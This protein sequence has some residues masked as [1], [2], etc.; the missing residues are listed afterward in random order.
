MN[1][2]IKLAFVMRDPVDRAWSAVNNAFKKGRI[3]GPLTVERALAR[4]LSSGVAARSA[5]VD[6]I[7][8]LETVFSRQQ[9]YF[10]FFEDLRDRPK[11]FVAE[12][13]SFLEVRPGD[14]KQLPS[15]AVNEVVGSRP[16][17]LEFKRTMAKAYMPMICELCQRF[18]GPPHAWRVRYEKLING[19]G[20]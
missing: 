15:G 18:E 19:S 11:G 13:L 4:A 14:L 6:T 12:L 7:K 16:V 10:C 2:D 20:E 17:P 1:V 3:E 5:Y 8:R 9:L